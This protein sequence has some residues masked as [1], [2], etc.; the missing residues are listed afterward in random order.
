[1]IAAAI[2]IVL[3]GYLAGCAARAPQVQP[4]PPV[5]PPPEEAAPRREQ[6]EATAYSVEGETASGRETRRGIVAADPHVLPIGTHV[7]IEGAGQYSG[8]YVVADTGRS[9]KGRK[10]D[11]FIP[12]ARAARHF[13]KR[14]V[15]VEILHNAREATTATP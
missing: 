3:Q 6:F 2:A 8:T 9:V 12:D 10:I 15:E 11:I 7:R 5:P 4:P 13:G 14:S 1:L